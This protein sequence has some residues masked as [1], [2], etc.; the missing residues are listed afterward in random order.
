MFEI[1]LMDLSALGPD[2][3]KCLSRLWQTHIL[4]AIRLF[5]FE[6]ATLVHRTFTFG[7][8]TLVAIVS[9]QGGGIIS[10][11]PALSTDIF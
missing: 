10:S 6:R 4:A 2:R 1:W 7:S 8:T 9:Q 11:I 5:T 3:H